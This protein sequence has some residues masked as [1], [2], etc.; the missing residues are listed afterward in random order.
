MSK[1]KSVC[2]ANG[3]LNMF[4]L[5][6]IYRLFKYELTSDAQKAQKRKKK[7]VIA[8]LN[9][10][11]M[12]LILKRAKTRLNINYKLRSYLRENKLYLP[13]QDGTTQCLHYYS[14]LTRRTRGHR[15]GTS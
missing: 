12:N 14:I 3:L 9:L 15:L 13:Y 8:T 6:V 7:F 10:P 5:R 1:L 2:N 11:P 4:Q